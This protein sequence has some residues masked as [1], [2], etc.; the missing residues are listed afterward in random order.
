VTLRQKFENRREVRDSSFVGTFPGYLVPVDAE[1]SR[2]EVR[3]IDVSR[4]GLG[5]IVSVKLEAGGF[6]WLILGEHKI[7]TEVAYCNSHLGIENLYRCGLFLREADG[8]LEAICRD[9]GLIKQTQFF[10]EP[11]AKKVQN[12]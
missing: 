3:P 12:G 4:R 5:F 2:I 10:P 7:R 8:D 1:L 9:K 6:Y 11:E